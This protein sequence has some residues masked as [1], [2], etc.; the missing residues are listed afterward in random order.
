M[1]ASIMVT[2][3]DIVKE[4]QF[5]VEGITVALYGVTP[6]NPDFV[7]IGQNAT[8]VKGSDPTVAEKRITGNVDRQEKT[9]TRE[10]NSVTLKF[11]FLSADEPI[12][13]RAQNLP[14]GA[15]TPDESITLF[16]SYNDDAVT[17]NETFEQFLGCKPITSTF[18][19]DNEGYLTLEVEYSVKTITIDTVG[20]TLGTGSFATPLTGTPLIHSDGG[21]SPFVYNSIAREQKAFSITVAFAEAIH[22]PS[23]TITDLFRRPTHRTISGTIDLFKQSDILDVD[24]RAVTSRAAVITIE[25]GQIV[26][27][28]TRFIFMPSG[29]EISGD[30]SDATIESKPFE[31]DVLVWA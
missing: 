23:G 31:A 21:A 8:L 24:A 6:T 12:L 10:K 1:A 14:N 20:P 27:T 5:I 15:G 19:Q 26:G 3:R 30:V 2:Q 29:E 28:F 22:D 17:P 11:L 13:A 7:A 25:T 9:K 18:T 4:P 16:Y